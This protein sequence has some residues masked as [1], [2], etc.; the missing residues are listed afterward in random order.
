MLPVTII[1]GLAALHG[2]AG[3]NGPTLFAFLLFWGWLLTFLMGVLQRILP[4]LASMHADRASGGLMPIMSEFATAPS[5]Y[6]HSACHGAAIVLI[7]L[8]ILTNLVWF[9]RAGCIVGLAG[10]FAF[11]WFAADVIRRITVTGR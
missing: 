3:P 7:G 10:A 9:M 11:S 8:A 6:V 2:L 5:L 1:A 4:F